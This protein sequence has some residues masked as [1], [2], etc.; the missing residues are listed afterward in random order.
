MKSGV[1]VAS[2]PKQFATNPLGSFAP[3]LLTYRLSRSFLP[4]GQIPWP[5]G[6]AVFYGS[7]KTQLRPG[8]L[9]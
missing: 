3:E 2:T 9:F 8:Q 4:S 7:Q 6:G 1:W 5:V